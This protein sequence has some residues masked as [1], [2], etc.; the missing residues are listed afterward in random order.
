MALNRE[1]LIGSNEWLLLLRC[2][3]QRYPL[4]RSVA[5]RVLQ[6]QREPRPREIGHAGR[7]TPVCSASALC[8]RTLALKKTAGQSKPRL[9]GAE[10]IPGR[11]VEYSE[12][13]LRLRH[14]L[15]KKT[16]LLK[17]WCWEWGTLASPLTLLK[18][19]SLSGA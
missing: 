14:V 11:A 13:V 17:Q 8:P 16:G 10:L 3:P 15:A 1:S 2:R 7:F 4:P 18:Q 6:P 5:A 9:M 12:A 19:A